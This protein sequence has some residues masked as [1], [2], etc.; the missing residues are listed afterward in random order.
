VPIPEEEFKVFLSHSEADKGLTRRI[1]ET[2]DRLHIRTFVYEHYPRG[3]INRFERIKTMIKGTPY[4]VALLT[5]NGLQSQWV[6]Q[7]I[8][9]A[10]GVGKMPI[11][12]IEVDPYTGERLK[13]RGFVELH[14]PILFNPLQPGA[15]VAK[16]IYTFYG[17]LTEAKNWPDKIW[18]TCKKCGNEFDGALDYQ[19]MLTA[20]NAVWCSWECTKCENRLEIYLPGLTFLE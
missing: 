4:F 20:R 1:S 19:K 15:M 12:I 11:P 3:G 2:L 18:L 17:W 6:N 10:V 13:S 7:E 9:Y 5:S 14:D 16:L 8:G